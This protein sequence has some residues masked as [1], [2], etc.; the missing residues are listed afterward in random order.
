MSFKGKILKI[1]I[2]ICIYKFLKSKGNVFKEHAK[3][4]KVSLTSIVSFSRLTLHT[5]NQKL[6]FKQKSLQ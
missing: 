3:T 4:Q 2:N 1:Y 6:F 5:Y